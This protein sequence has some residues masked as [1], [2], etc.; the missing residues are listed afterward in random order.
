MKLMTDEKEP[1][2]LGF[3]HGMNSLFST[4]HKMFSPDIIY[5]EATKLTH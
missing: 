1:K 2:S 4:Q 5:T 3:S